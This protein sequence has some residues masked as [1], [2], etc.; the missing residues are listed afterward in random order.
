ML[1]QTR[2]DAVRPYYR[3]FLKAF[4]TVRRLAAAPLDRVLKLWEGLGYYARARNLRAAARRLTGPAGAWPRTA[5]AWGRLPG[6]GRYTAGAIASIA[7][8]ERTP[9]VDGNVR[10]VLARF[11]LLRDDPG[12]RET[13]ARLWALAGELVPRRQPGRFNQA[14][15]EL[16]ARVCLPRNPDC[17]RCPLRNACAARAQ[18]L[19][20]S[21]P[22]KKP[23][24]PLPHHRV[25]VA[26]I[27][28]AGR[29]LIGR[30]PERGLL[31]GLWEFPG[32]RLE[33]GETPERAL[34]RGVRA[35][36]GVSLAV[37]SLLARVR[38][39]YT[40][41]SIEMSAYDCR[42]AAGEPRPRVHTALRWVSRRELRRYAFPG[43]NR[44]ILAALRS[45]GP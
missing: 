45:P 17:P 41:F 35:E 4:P 30:R 14:L 15:M 13:V 36:L 27:S 21:V 1:Q 2:V 38:H 7:L 26:V 40:H 25:A 42:V 39:A 22:G 37:G 8:G 20:A 3:R 16:G 11:F 28:R 12:R 24:G 5:E 33:A 18:G 31:G 29:V 6:V 34:V 44:K 43:A 9:V 19:Q 10:R 23:R 32:G